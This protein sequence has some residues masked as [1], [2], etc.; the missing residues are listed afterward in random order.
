[1]R[2]ARRVVTARQSLGPTLLADLAPP[3]E[4]E[5]ALALIA[6]AP[7]P[8]P[9]P[10]TSVAVATQWR[11]R[12]RAAAR[13][14]ARRRALAWSWRAGGAMNRG[15]VWTEARRL[16]ALARLNAGASLACVVVPIVDGRGVE[17]E[18]HALAL[19]LPLKSGLGPALRPAV[20]AAVS[21]IARAALAPRLRRL[22]R[23]LA[24]VIRA[25]A[26]ADTAVMLRLRAMSEPEKQPGLFEGRTPRAAALAESADLTTETDARA[27]EADRELALEIGIPT[28]VL[29]VRRP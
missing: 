5:I 17:I 19:A 6:H 9:T 27:A 1:M 29:L 16:P 8:I 12:A 14:L 15:G 18:R 13:L 4:R 23:R 7:A 22:A 21:D 10:S 11:R 25:G 20:R 3:A 2:L 28:L 26:L 24:P